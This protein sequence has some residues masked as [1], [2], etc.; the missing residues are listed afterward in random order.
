MKYPF[1]RYLKSGDVRKHEPQQQVRQDSHLRTSDKTGCE[2]ELP[3]LGQDSR[4]DNAT[5]VW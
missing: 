3:S 5:P 1:I 4:M 2:S